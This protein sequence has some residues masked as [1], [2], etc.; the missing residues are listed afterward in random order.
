MKKIFPPS[1]HL[2]IT[3]VWLVISL[4]MIFLY[5]PREAT[6]GEAQRIFTFIFQWHARHCLLSFSGI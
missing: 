1:I 6:M 4:Y 3:F 5:A 2:A